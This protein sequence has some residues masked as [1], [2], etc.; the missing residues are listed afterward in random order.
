MAP[1]SLQILS[2]GIVAS[3]QANSNDDNNGGGGGGL[4]HGA[5]SGI[6][7][8][9]LFV[10][11]IISLILRFALRVYLRDRAVEREIQNRV[12]RGE[13]IDLTTLDEND[14]R[15]PTI[16]NNRTTTKQ[17]ATTPQVR[18]GMLEESQSACPLGLMNMLLPYKKPRL[19]RL[20]RFVTHDL[21]SSRLR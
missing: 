6:V 17:P 7:I 10:V 19:E 11:G 8:A 20:N 15:Y 3:R 13:I 18:P 14:P 16:N 4:S 2:R 9:V 5:V 12:A 21:R 1:N